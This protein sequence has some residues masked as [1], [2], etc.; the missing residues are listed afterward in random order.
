MPS[1]PKVQ[2]WTDLLAALLRRN[3]PVD[4][5]TLRQE[6]P[7]Y[8]EPDRSE[9]ATM[10]MFERDK[11]DL[12]A[13]GVPIESVEDEDGNLSLY[14][15]ASRQF[16][17]PYLHLASERPTGIRRPKGP[18]YQALSVLAFEPEELE[19]VGRAA[20][21]VAALGDPALAHEARIAVRKLGHDLPIA[22]VA[23]STEHIALDQPPAGTLLDLLNDALRRRKI[24]TFTYRS[25]QRDASDVRS[26]EPYGLVFLS[27]HWYLI[28]RDTEADARRQ[29]RVSRISDATVN[30]KRA[31]SA[32]FEMPRD[33]ELASYARSRQA[34]EIGDADHQDVVVEFMVENGYTMP[35][36]QLGISVDGF[37]MRRRFQVRRPDTFALWILGY[38]G[39]ARVVSPPDVAARVT[40]L[41]EQT[42]ARYAQ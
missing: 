4:F 39:D 40:E 16:Y 41:A 19:A 26:V 35:A 27:G 8:C 14:R 6:V 24:L 1:Q 36:M 22:A 12:R 30:A 11:D 15:L 10:R 13:L 7:A 20:Q 38:A 5:N 37:P 34:W 21:R 18:G 28:G 29:F 42:L 3:F 25:M 33:F 9:S 2:R 17:L 23:R 31:Q 32:D